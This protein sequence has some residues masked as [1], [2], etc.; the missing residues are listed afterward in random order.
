MIDRQIDSPIPMPAGLVVKKALNSWS[1]FV[2]PMPWPESD[3]SNRRVLAVHIEFSADVL[4]R[5]TRVGFQ[6]IADEFVRSTPT[7]VAL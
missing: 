4:R 3:I 1:R 7:R 2:D 5:R 6:T